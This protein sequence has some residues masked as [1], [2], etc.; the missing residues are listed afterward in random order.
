MAYDP[1]QKPG[2]GEKGEKGEKGSPGQTDS[3]DPLENLIRRWL[4]RKSNQKGLTDSKEKKVKKNAGQNEI[5]LD[6]KE[7]E[8]E[9]SGNNFSLRRPMM[10]TD[11]EEEEREIEGAR[12]GGKI[13]SKP[14]QLAGKMLASIKD[15]IQSNQGKRKGKHS[16]TKSRQQRKNGDVE[17]QD[18]EDDKEYPE[19]HKDFRSYQQEPK[20]RQQRK[21][22][23]KKPR[24]VRPAP[25]RSAVKIDL[26]DTNGDIDDQGHDYED[27]EEYPETHKEFDFDLLK[28]IP[29]SNYDEPY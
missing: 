20:S 2:E 6:R 7:D 26:E 9:E 17:D 29:D 3:R 14:A 8:E 27:G 16:K 15:S 1:R 25:P 4:A 28:N 5:R 11:D 19:M 24:F 21:K 18:Y 10:E 12:L 23:P 22:K 13:K